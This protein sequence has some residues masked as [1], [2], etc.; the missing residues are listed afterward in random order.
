MVAIVQRLGQ[1]VVVPLMRVRFSLATHLSY[2]C[3]QA[4]C[5]ACVKNRTPELNFQL[6]I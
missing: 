5:L 6:K 4:N 1:R 2:N 3:K